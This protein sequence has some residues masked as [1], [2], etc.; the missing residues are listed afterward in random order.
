MQADDAL[1]GAAEEVADGRSVNWDALAGRARSDDERAQLECLRLVDA[2]GRAHRSTGDSGSAGGPGA[3]TAPDRPA[4]PDQAGAEARTWGRYR[5]LQE[6]GAGSYGSVYRAWDPELEREVAIKILHRQV[7]DSELRDRLLHEGR[8]L[9][10]VRD[11]HVVSV[12][13]VESYGD[14]VGLCM[15]FV[16]GDTLEAVLRSHGSLNAREAT[17][18]GQ[19]VCRALAAVHQAGFVHRDVKLRNVMRSRT[20]RIVLMDFGTGRDTEDEAERGHTNVVGTPAY[21]APE[22][23]AGEPATAASDV[24]SVGVLLYHLV[25]GKYPIEGSTI[26]EIR[27]AHMQGRRTLLADRRADLPLPFMQL[28]DRALAPDPALRWPS[29]GALLDALGQAGG[30]VETKKRRAVRLAATGAVVLLGTGTLL[31]VLGAISSKFFNT[32][33]L[34]RDGFVHESVWDWMY[35]GAVSLTAP[36]VVLMLFLLGISLLLVFRRLLISTSETARRVDAAAATIARRLKWD[37]VTMA[38]C[39]ALLASAAILA[40]AWAACLPML[41]LLLGIFPDDVSTAPAGKLAF[42]SPD[43]APTHVNYRLWFTWSTILCGAV[44]VPVVRLAARQGTTVSPLM[45]LGGAVVVVLSFALLSLPH[46]TFSRSELETASWQGQRCYILGERAD[47]LLVF[48]P[49]LGPP[50]SRVVPMASTELHRFGVMESVF[51]RIRLAK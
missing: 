25:T 10:R 16:H 28:V 50:R 38:S 9:A 14:R 35:W 5:L 31:T 13:G 23:L 33:I 26:A 20:G 15:E 37:D 43:V 6:V 4:V 34:G 48:C 21:M 30:D 3:E 12:L 41:E 19:D 17:L 8:A 29:A 32:F 24:Y 44:W 1:L 7:A 42:L 40:V 39:W 27:A 49:E 45:L 46:R 47:D 22:V 18:V 36:L 51:T 2:I 11:A